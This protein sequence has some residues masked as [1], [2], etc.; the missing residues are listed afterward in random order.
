MVS[1]IGADGKAE[2]DFGQPVGGQKWTI[3]RYGIRTDDNV[4][5]VSIEIG[6]REIDHAYVLPQYDS[7]DG[8]AAAYAQGGESVRMK[9]GGATPGVQVFGEIEFTVS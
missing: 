8:S 4:G 5:A 3:H 1:R 9:I 2:L 6:Y 7:D